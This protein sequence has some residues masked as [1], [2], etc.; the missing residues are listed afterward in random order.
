MSVL[1]SSILHYSLPCICIIWNVIWYII[2]YVML[3][4]F[5]LLQLS[6]SE[7]LWG[8]LNFDILFLKSSFSTWNLESFT[9]LPTSYSY[10]IFFTSILFFQLQ[11]K[12]TWLVFIANMVAKNFLSWQTN[13]VVSRSLRMKS[14]NGGYFNVSTPDKIAEARRKTIENY[15]TLNRLLCLCR[16]KQIRVHNSCEYIN[17]QQLFDNFFI[18]QN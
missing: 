9:N 7:S 16:V 15:E 3:S 17:G 10:L 18:N 8:R 6:L 1:N 13:W 11:L 5:W 12:C 4:L 14:G 2:W